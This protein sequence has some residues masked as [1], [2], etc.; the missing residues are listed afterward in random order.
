MID[1]AS[2]RM[3]QNV[4]DMA[5]AIDGA[6]RENGRRSSIGSYGS[7]HPERSEGAMTKG[8]PPSLRSG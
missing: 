7:C 2:A 6:G 5:A 4:V 8:M 1:A 3:A